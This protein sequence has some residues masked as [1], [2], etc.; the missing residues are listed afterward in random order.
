M[1]VAPGSNEALCNPRQIIPLHLRRISVF[2]RT[3][4]VAAFLYLHDDITIRWIANAF[5]G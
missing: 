2:T 1:Q 3:F 5:R 4:V